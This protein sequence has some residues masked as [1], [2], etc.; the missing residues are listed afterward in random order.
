MN[1][2]CA[3]ASRPLANLLL[4]GEG[5]SRAA[6]FAPPSGPI[7]GDAWSSPPVRQYWKL[8]IPFTWGKESETLLAAKI[9]QLL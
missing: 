7:V 6:S 3:T 4:D 5:Y 1:S 9:S 2:A 8:G